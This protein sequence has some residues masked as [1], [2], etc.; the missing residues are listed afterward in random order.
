M[1]FGPAAFREVRHLKF[2]HLLETSAPSIC[3]PLIW[4][5]QKVLN[6]FRLASLDMWYTGYHISACRL[7]VSFHLGY[8]RILPCYG[9]SFCVYITLFFFFKVCVVLRFA[10]EISK[11]CYN[12]TG[13]LCLSKEKVII[14]NR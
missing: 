2:T 4:A 9:N 7:F 6:A 3:S 13:F 10:F 8:A 12:V 14:V 5:P 11:C 1:P